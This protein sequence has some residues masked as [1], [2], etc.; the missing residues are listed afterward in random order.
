M[1]LT[2]GFSVHNNRLNKKHHVISAY[3][4]SYTTK[5]WTYAPIFINKDLIIVVLK[6][7]KNKQSGQKLSFFLYSSGNLIKWKNLSSKHWFT[8]IFSLLMTQ[9]LELSTI[10]ALFCLSTVNQSPKNSIHNFPRQPNDAHEKQNIKVIYNP[11]CDFHRSH[12]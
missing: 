3:A 10:T 1:K 8:K 5:D 6:I 12:F 9:T 11:V 4:Y 2:S 7:I